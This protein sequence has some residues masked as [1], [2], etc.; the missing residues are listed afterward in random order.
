[1]ILRFI[2]IILYLNNQEDCKLNGHPLFVPD[3]RHL[4][5]IFIET[6]V[7]R[8]FECSLYFVATKFL[9]IL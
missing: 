8:S 4:V 9:L 7:M 3:T 2:E 5:F 6:S 1:M